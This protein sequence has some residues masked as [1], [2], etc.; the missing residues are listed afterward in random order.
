MPCNAPRALILAVTCSAVF[1]SASPAFADP[2][3]LAAPTV[4]VPPNPLGMLVADFN[5]DGTPD[6]AV[7]SANTL[8]IFPG[9]GDGRFGARGDGHLAGGTW[10]RSYRPVQIVNLSLADFNGDCLP[11]LVTTPWTDAAVAVQPGTG[12][13]TL[14]GNS[15]VDS[16]AAGVACSAIGDLN[17]DCS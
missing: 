6:L 17:G 7:T 4:V 3:F 8:S 13:A 1:S 10:L 15:V 11:D 9:T 2:V 14:V 12:D 16:T 5:G